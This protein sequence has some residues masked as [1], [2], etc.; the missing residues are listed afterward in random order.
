MEC[1]FVGHWPN[2]TVLKEERNIVGIIKENT[3]K[4][5]LI[6]AMQHSFSFLRLR[7]VTAKQSCR[8]ALFEGALSSSPNDRE[9]EKYFHH[10]LSATLKMCF[11]PNPTTI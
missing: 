7:D 9:K 5:N 6:A 4:K 1:S 3:N 11:H 8:L 2:V 10:L